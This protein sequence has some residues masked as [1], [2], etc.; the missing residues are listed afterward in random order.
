[1]DRIVI[2]PRQPVVRFVTLI[3]GDAGRL[4]LPLISSMTTR[5]FST[6]VTSVSCFCVFGCFLAR[7][8]DSSSYQD[9]QFNTD[10]NPAQPT[11]ATN[12]AGE[13]S[14]SIVVGF[15]AVGWLPELAGFG[16]QTGI[17]DLGFQNPEDQS[18]GQV[19]MSIPN[20][21]GVEEKDFTDM[22]LRVVYFVDGTIYKTNLTFSPPGATFVSRAVIEALPPPLGGNWVEDLFRWHLTPSPTNISLVIT[23]AAG[24]TV[25]DRIRVETAGPPVP[26]LVITSV[27]KST[28]GLA[29]GWTGGL[30]PYQIYGSTNLDAGSW[31]AIG[32]SLS[33]TNV[34]VP[35]SGP[36]WFL[37]V[38]GGD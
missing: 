20:P 24:G 33:V 8:A 22:A 11:L 16:H 18:R 10:A 36:T 35:L 12:S 23:G 5:Q 27:Q 29:L 37:R 17:W 2:D 25:L 15:G 3:D 4:V 7:A 30:P 14:A 28:Q 19:I 6:V 1:M 21:A 13:A 31:E 38:A 32:S 34:D 9:W 26:P